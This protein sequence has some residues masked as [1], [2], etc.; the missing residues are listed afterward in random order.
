MKLILLSLLTLVP[1]TLGLT[2]DDLVNPVALSI[3]ESVANNLTAVAT[4]LIPKKTGHKFAPVHSLALK[5]VQNKFKQAAPVILKSHSKKI[6]KIRKR[7]GP[8][9]SKRQL[10]LARVESLLTLRDL[11]VKLF[12]LTRE[13]AAH[14]KRQTHG[15]VEK[16]YFAR[17]NYYRTAL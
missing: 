15:L 7:F 2:L 12:T 8:A 5:K 3:T 13:E 4:T 1:D 6:L 16:R 10:S 14:L 9:A 17:A 11:Q